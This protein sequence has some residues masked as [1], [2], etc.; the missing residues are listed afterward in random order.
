MLDSVAAWLGVALTA[1]TVVFGVIPLLQARKR[2]RV[3]MDLQRR[4]ISIV[5]FFDSEDATRPYVFGSA[6]NIGSRPVALE[7]WH[8]LLP[9]GSELDLPSGKWGSRGS[10]PLELPPDSDKRSEHYIEPHDLA[11]AVREQQ[12]AGIVKLRGQYRDHTGKAFTSRP[13]AFDTD[14]WIGQHK[15]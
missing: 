6:V 8:I 11:K 2:L 3:T 9:D 1:A 5:Y 15:E 14:Y 7:S 4:D 13:F 12:L 10:L